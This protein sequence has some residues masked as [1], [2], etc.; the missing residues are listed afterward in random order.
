MQ[1]GRR[2]ALKSF[3]MSFVVWIGGCAEAGS[4]AGAPVLDGGDRPD[5]LYIFDLP[6]ADGGDVGPRP[7]AARDLA[8][9]GS[10]A[11]CPAEECDPR[12]RRDCGES[13]CVL[14]AATPACGVAGEQIAGATCTSATDC[15]RGLGCFQRQGQ[16]ECAPVCCPGD[17]VC[18]EGQTCAAPSVL[19][20]G[21]LTAWG[22]CTAPRPCSIFESGEMCEPGEACY[23]VSATGETDC[24]IA[25]SGQTGAYCSEQNDCAPGFFCGGL[26]GSAC[27]RICER[28]GTRATC[29]T[30]EGDCVV[31]AHSPPG[32]GLCAHMMVPAR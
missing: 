8:H 18:D 25:G 4:A 2:I 1:E 13:S 30:D 6:G 23:I 22:R 15:A 28:A 27:V 26:T 14:S 21:A 29:L 24:R 5:Q 9:D 3:L 16:G 12:L 20:D 7:D 10:I 17:G 32:T 31:Y 11:S 19:V